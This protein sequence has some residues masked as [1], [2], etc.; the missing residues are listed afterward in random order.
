MASFFWFSEISIPGFRHKCG[1]Y[2]KPM[3]TF[4]D[5]TC[6]KPTLTLRSSLQPKQRASTV[7]EAEGAEEDGQ[8]EGYH[9]DG[10]TTI[11]HTGT[12]CRATTC[13]NPDDRHMGPPSLSPHKEGAGGGQATGPLKA[14]LHPK[15][16]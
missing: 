5:K 16:R 12:P 1:V 10:H 14:W 9:L 15:Q 3:K 13:V 11:S 2:S 6:T 4:Q 7:K 8:E